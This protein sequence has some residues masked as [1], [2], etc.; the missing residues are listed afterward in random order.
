MKCASVSGGEMKTR[1]S[2]LGC[3][4]LLGWAAV[5]G[6]T[7]EAKP[8]ALRTWL[9]AKVDEATAARAV[10]IAK[11]KSPE[12]IAARQKV[13]REKFV[14]AIGGFPERTALNAA[15]KGVVK[16][17]GYSVEKILFESRP[18][19]FVTAA[20]FLPDAAKFAPPWPGIA[21]PCG[22]SDIGKAIEPYQRG[23]ALAALNGMAALVFD[24]IEQGERGRGSVNGHNAI[25]RPGMLV[26]VPMAQIE[27]WDGMRAIDYLQSRS[28][29]LK[30]K[31]GCM[32]NSGGGTQTSYLVALDDRIV[33]ASPSCYVTTLAQMTRSIGPQDA[34]Q[35]IFGQLAFG[36][37]HADY[38]TMRAPTPVLICSAIQDFFPIAGARGAFA[39]SKTIF[40]TLGKPDRISMAEHDS[41]HGWAQPLREAAVRWMCR[42][43]RGVDV[44]VK[45]PATLTI[46]SETEIQVTESGDVMK[47]PGA[48]SPYEILRE[49][50]AAFPARPK[51]T[52]E[53]IGRVT[54]KMACIHDAEKKATLTV[55]SEEP[56]KLGGVSR[57]VF[58]RDG[59]PLPALVYMPAQPEKAAPVLVIHSDGQKKAQAIAE[60]KVAEGLMVL[61]VDLRGFGETANAK[62]DFYRDADGGDAFIAYL[63]G[64]TLV[65]QR[66]EDILGAA[67]WLAAETRGIEVVAANWAVT[68][69]L[70]A[71][72]VEPKLFARVTLVDAPESW[73]DV[74]LKPGK[75]PYSDLVHGV[76]REYDV[77][78]LKAA[79][80]EKVGK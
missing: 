55:R 51:R 70:H 18:G 68:P 52:A 37:D 76:L 47:L 67:R 24:P 36:M 13:L 5:C 78:E 45:E 71:A 72:L 79:L 26:G 60:K 34:E 17:D 77:E 74:L 35:N 8:G 50:R 62:E 61:S 44:D 1:V 4:A 38:V 41:K 7:I 20:L 33:A 58:E 28:D 64:E 16:K 46:L 2:V 23:A 10:E 27:I 40:E 42:W 21:V 30:D 31:I 59:M 39:E 14:A 19:F 69:A 56:R 43:L 22:H 9:L 65:G 49:L 63:L 48:K 12:L 32:G 53:E 29:I 80:G 75:H 57:V 73:N 6:E 11:L 25:G 3:L 54:A 66:A 15:V